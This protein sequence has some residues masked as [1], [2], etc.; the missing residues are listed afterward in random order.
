MD[1]HVPLPL[2]HIFGMPFI[3]LRQAITIAEQWVYL[4]RPDVFKACLLLVLE[5]GLMF[6]YQH[7]DQ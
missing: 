4:S 7:Q 3:V 1:I 2:R 5:F 6:T